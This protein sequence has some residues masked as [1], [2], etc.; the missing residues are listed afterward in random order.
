VETPLFECR[1]G[2]RASVRDVS[3]ARVGSPERFAMNRML[4]ATA[5]SAL[6]AASVPS[7]A[8]QATT[9]DQ[10]IGT[11]KVVSFSTHI[12]GVPMHHTRGTRQ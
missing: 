10:I 2:I 11:W 9:K 4:N 1:I 8:Q 3:A 12:I 7:Y 5:I 6:L